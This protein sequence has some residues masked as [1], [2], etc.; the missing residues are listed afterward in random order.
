M[1]GEG[2]SVSLVYGRR[3]VG[4][5]NCDNP[6]SK[7]NGEFDIVSLNE[8]GYAFYEAKFSKNPIGAET[9]EKEIE[10]VK[11]TGLSCYKYAFFSRSAFS[12]EHKEGVEFIDLHELFL[13]A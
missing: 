2:L 6:I 5:Y 9:I 11:A 10:Q 7:S 8:K 1:K 4:K 13:D 3:R 12:I